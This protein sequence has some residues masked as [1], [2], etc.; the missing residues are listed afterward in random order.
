M[1]RGIDGAAGVMVIEVRTAGVTVSVAEGE[2][3]ESNIAVMNVVPVLRDVTSPL[4]AALLLIVATA[5]FDENQVAHL[6][7]L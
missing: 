7:K 2:L 4:V 6:V 3:T 1:P 5:E